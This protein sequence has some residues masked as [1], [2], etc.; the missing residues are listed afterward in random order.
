[1][2]L[3]TS[4]IAFISTAF[5]M[6]VV[7][8]AGAIKFGRTNQKIEKNCNEV[9][10]LKSELKNTDGSPTYVLKSDCVSSTKEFRTSMYNKISELKGSIDEIKKLSI[11]LHDKQQIRIDKLDQK[12]EDAK[13]SYLEQLRSISIFMAKVETFM[14]NYQGKINDSRR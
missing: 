8:V 14:N 5:S 6:L 2:K 9:T 1:M 4:I 13:D 3:D 12:R 10:K 7:L 11:E